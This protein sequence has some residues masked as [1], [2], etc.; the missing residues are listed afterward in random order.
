MSQNIYYI[1]FPLYIIKNGIAMSSLEQLNYYLQRNIQF[2]FHS[3]NSSSFFG[4]ELESNTSELTSAVFSINL[5]NQKTEAEKYHI[6][7]AQTT[8]DSKWNNP[9]YRGMER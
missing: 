5:Y 4:S 8:F 6:V 9:I 7:K 2:P 3:L 1:R